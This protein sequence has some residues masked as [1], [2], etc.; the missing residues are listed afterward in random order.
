MNLAV[1]NLLFASLYLI[2]DLTYIY[3]S[4]TTYNT[5]VQRISGKSMPGLS[6]PAAWIFFGVAYGALIGGWLFFVTPAVSLREILTRAVVYAC[7]TYGVFN[8]TMYCMFRDY[9]MKIAVRDMAWGLTCVIL[10]SVLYY[11]TVTSK[12]LRLSIK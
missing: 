4:S 8:G 2:I 5:V 9:D 12:Y 1:T 10:M 11:Y 7:V 3:L 6:K